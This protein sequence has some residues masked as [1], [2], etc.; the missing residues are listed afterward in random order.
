MVVGGGS[1]QNNLEC[2]FF[3]QENPKILEHLLASLNAFS[4]AMATNARGRLCKIGE[5]IFPHILCLWG[6]CQPAV[7][8]QVVE[9]L[10]FQMK[11]HHPQGTHTDDEGAWASNDALWKVIYHISCLFG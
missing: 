10:R 8:D 9:F 7:K 3:S 2:F 4:V 5:D 6:R 11:V 1:S